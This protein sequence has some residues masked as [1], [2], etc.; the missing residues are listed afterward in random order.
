MSI[1]DAVSVVPVIVL[2]VGGIVVVSALSLIFIGSERLTQRLTR[3]LP[4][5]ED[6]GGAGAGELFGEQ[7]LI[8]RGHGED[9]Y[10]R[11]RDR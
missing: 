3:G 10:P 6:T 8:A 1:I 7:G 11:D 2:I 9:L 4:K 5:R